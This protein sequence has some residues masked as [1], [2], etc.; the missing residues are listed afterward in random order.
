MHCLV[1]YGMKRIL[2]QQN[3]NQPNGTFKPLLYFL[4]LLVVFQAFYHFQSCAPI[5]ISQHLEPSEQHTCTFLNPIKKS[6][7]CQ[8]KAFQNFHPKQHL[9]PALDFYFHKSHIQHCA[10]FPDLTIVIIHHKELTTLLTTLHSY[11]RANL[12]SKVAEV[13]LLAS[14]ET[15]DCE[16]EIFLNYGITTIIKT[17]KKRHL[18]AQLLK[19]LQHIKTPYFLF[20]EN[21]WHLIRADWENVVRGGLSILELNKAVQIRLTETSYVEPF[22]KYEGYREQLLCEMMRSR[23]TMIK[24]REPD[25]RKVKALNESSITFVF[26]NDATFVCT[27][28]DVCRWSNRPYLMSTEWANEHLKPSIEEIV[29]ES[30]ESMLEGAR[31]LRFNW[32]KKSFP[33]C[34]TYDKGIFNHREIDSEARHYNP[35]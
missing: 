20:L 16:T 28:T 18:G 11:L 5:N 34:L 23:S 3:S 30:P 35:I 21:D 9:L 10:Q 22:T 12:T 13:L 15:I 7:E 14:E 1:N 8:I 31:P 17:P 6:S 24:F 19:A 4:I 25:P 32:R 2:K 26:Q 29:K 27:T 33:V